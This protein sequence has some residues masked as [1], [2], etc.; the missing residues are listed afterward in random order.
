MPPTTSLRS[1]DLC[2][3]A[4]TLD[5]HTP[6]ATGS[7]VCLVSVCVCVCV[8]VYVCKGGRCECACGE[9]GCSKFV[10]LASVHNSV[11][12]WHLLC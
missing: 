6:L 11:C 4:S 12:L 8:C 10:S 1:L 9:K 2:S 3:P 5:E 7:D